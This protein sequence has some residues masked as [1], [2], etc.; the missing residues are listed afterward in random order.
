M[1]IVRTSMLTDN[2]NSWEIDVTEEQLAN[3]QSG[4]LIHEAMPHLTPQEREFI[5]TGIMPDEWPNCP[6]D[7]C[8]IDQEFDEL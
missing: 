8:V 1:K 7:V 3:W 5:M 2:T 6:D 4:T